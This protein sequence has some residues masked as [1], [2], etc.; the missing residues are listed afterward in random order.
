[1]AKQ[2]ELS[3]AAFSAAVSAAGY[4]P[5]QYSNTGYFIKT[6]G[7]IRLE[8]QTTRGGVNSVGYGSSVPVVDQIEKFLDSQ[9][10][11]PLKKIARIKGSIN[12][13]YEDLAKFISL[14]LIVEGFKAEGAAKPVA[15]VSVAETVETVTEPVLEASPEVEAP[16]VASEPETEVAATKPKRDRSKKK[17]AEAKAANLLRIKAIA[18]TLPSNQAPVT[19]T[20]IVISQSDVEDMPAFLTHE[21]V[22]ELLGA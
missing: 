13:A 12:Y 2:I 15:A 1:M 20:P 4:K 11:L 16:V 17:G 14:A 6:A 9:P 5:T 22:S 7:G 21:S 3:Y 18:K 19:E 10:E 8:M